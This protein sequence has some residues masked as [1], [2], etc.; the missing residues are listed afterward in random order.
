MIENKNKTDAMNGSDISLEE[1]VENDGQSET[2]FGQSEGGMF[3][4]E[5]FKYLLYPTSTL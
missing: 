2:V 5:T 3:P 1:K 4:S